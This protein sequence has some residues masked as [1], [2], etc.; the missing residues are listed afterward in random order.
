MPYDKKYT[1]SRFL[2]QIHSP[3]PVTPFDA[4]GEF[5]PEAFA[6]V[7]GYHLDVVKVDTMLIAGCNGEG[8]A[9]TDDE[10]GQVVKVCAKVVGKRIPYFVHVSRTRTAECIRR[11][12]IA[13]ENGATGIAL[14]QPQIYDSSE[15]KVIERF[16]EVARAV[17][18]PMM[19]YNLSH[20]SH[21]S[22]SPALTN[23]ICDVAPVEVLKDVPTDF[24]HIKRMIVEV[25][26]RIPVLYGHKDTLVPALLL[27]GGGFVGTGPEIFGAECR[28]LFFEV[29]SM[30]PRERMDLHWR[31]GLVSDALMWKIGKPPAGIKAAMT[32]IGVYAGFPR[33]HIEPL[34]SAEERQLRDIF[35]KARVLAPERVAKRA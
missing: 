15:S 8:Y 19:I 30:T 11:A 28:K 4:T 23:A 3:A 14:G 27:G 18:L 29:H 26:D 9:L 6:K 22:L 24:D 35:V 21:F 25:G 1:Q 31:Y 7:L 2:G 12:E 20:L 5:L 10:L 16:K 13:A 17:P 32:M 34:T 33:D